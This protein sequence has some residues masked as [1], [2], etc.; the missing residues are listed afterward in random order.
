MHQ[1]HQGAGLAGCVKTRGSCRPRLQAKAA[2]PELRLAGKTLSRT[3]QAA[4]QRGTSR[5]CRGAGMPDSQS[6]V[7]PHPHAPQGRQSRWCACCTPWR[8]SPLPCRRTAGVDMTAVSIRGHRSIDCESQS[9][10]GIEQRERSTHSRSW[11]A[12]A[13]CSCKHTKPAKRVLR[14][15]D[16]ISSQNCQG[17]ACL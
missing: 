5:S 3:W 17:L 15:S 7:G 12:G 6:C 14:P 10:P 4:H 11:H 2:T 8:R 13:G 9:A 16:A 1:C